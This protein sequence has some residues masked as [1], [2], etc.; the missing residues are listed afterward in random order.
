MTTIS[1]ALLA[2][3]EKFWTG[4]ADFFQRNLD[5][6]CLIACARMTGVFSR[7]EVVRSVLNGNRWKDL[8]LKLKGVI[9][10]VAGV[11]ILTYQARATRETGEAYAALVSTA[12]AKRDGGWKMTFHQQTPLEDAES[13]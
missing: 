9:E 13:V 4:D 6:S 1:K 2:L 7:G 5:D 10:P 3:E 12:Y 8:E 11:A